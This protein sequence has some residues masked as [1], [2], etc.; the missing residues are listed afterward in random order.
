MLSRIKRWYDSNDPDNYLYLF[1][2]IDSDLP[3]EELE[4]KL[5]EDF[6]MEEIDIF[7]LERFRRK[8]ST[9]ILK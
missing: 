8:H 2:D 9:T 6:S 1:Q 4:K 7:F 3:D 5:Q